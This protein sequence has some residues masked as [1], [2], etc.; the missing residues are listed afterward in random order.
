MFEDTAIQASMKIKDMI[1]EVCNDNS[2]I[3]LAALIDHTMLSPST[4][5]KQIIEHCQEAK[6]HHF[7]AVAVNLTHIA[8]AARELKGSGVRVC[9]PIGFPLGATY[10]CVKVQE[11]LKAIEDGATE[12]D[13]VINIG[14]LKSGNTE[15]VRDEIKAIVNNSKNKALVK[16]IIEA[17]Y[18]TD[19]EKVTVCRIAKE[20][21]A[22]YV[23]TST[24]MGKGGATVEDVKLMRET[25]GPNMGVKASGGIRDYKTAIAMVKAGANRLGTSASVI[26]V[27]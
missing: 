26:I 21:G 18:L 13:M 22:D 9:A 5:E 8:L 17:C 16:I 4:T 15:L 14:A 7:M 20:E 24:G 3:N 1:D 27:S 11:T 6:K 25:V 23:K 19:E 10:S 2:K 12:V